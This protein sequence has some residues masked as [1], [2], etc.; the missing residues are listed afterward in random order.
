MQELQHLGFQPFDAWV[1]LS[2]HNKAPLPG[3]PAPD[4]ANILGV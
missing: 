3:K 4:P 1:L 2:V